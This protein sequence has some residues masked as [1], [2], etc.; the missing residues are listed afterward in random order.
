VSL[1]KPNNLSALA[2]AV[3]IVPS[4]ARILR[5]RGNLVYVT[6]TTVCQRERGPRCFGQKLDSRDGGERLGGFGS[7][8]PHARGEGLRLCTELLDRDAWPSR[9]LPFV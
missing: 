3:V 2:R 4:G 6:A 5:D 1:D 8:A 7:G 9:G